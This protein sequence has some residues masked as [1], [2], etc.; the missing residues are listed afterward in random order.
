MTNITIV[1]RCNDEGRKA[2]ILAGRTGDAV[3]KI[4]VQSD[5]PKYAE[6]LAQASFR[7]DV[8][9][10]DTDIY[11]PSTDGAVSLPPTEWAVVPTVEQI[12][13]DQAARLAEANRQ[14]AEKHARRR[15]DALAVLRDRRVRK[16]YTYTNGECYEV[17]N[18][19]WPY[20]ADPAVTTC[21]EAQ[22][23][24]AELK[25]ANDAAEV[26]AKEAAIR[27]AAEEKERKAA[28]KVKEEER[29]AS[30]GLGDGD[31]DFAI[32]N[33][34]LTRVPC[35]ESHARGKNWLA[36]ITPDPTAP[37]GFRRVF[38]TA[39]KDDSYY[40]LPDWKPGDAVEFGADYYTG[41]GR[42]NSNRWYGYVVRQ[43][44]GENGTGYVVLH[45]CG[46][47]KAAYKEGQK[48]AAQAAKE[49]AKAQAARG[50]EDAL[51]ACWQAVQGLP[52]KEA[53]KV[54]AELKAR[55]AA[56]KE[57]AGL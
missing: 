7:N 17:I 16:S 14:A 57:P 9:V 13:N 24:L 26:A 31:R 4:L 45:E 49:E 10:L 20:N 27:K 30:L 6:I 12:L 3:Q 34:C 19:D 28:A 55:L 47:G 38:A 51:E 2:H 15:E 5:H 35:W 54:L 50:F 39:A 23:W 8:P 33:G 40:L 37:G 11:K 18:P 44:L 36:V 22:A 52:E 1:Y 41:G 48:H 46:T 21:P 32:E 53:R 25:A 56:K 29:R 42:K 43:V